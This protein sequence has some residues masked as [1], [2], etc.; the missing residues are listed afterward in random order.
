MATKKREKVGSMPCEGQNCESHTIGRP[1]I[2]YKS[3]SGTLGYKCDICGRG[4]YVKPEDDAH[5]EWLEAIKPD[6]APPQPSASVVTVA[7]SEILEDAT[8][9]TPAA[10]PPKPLSFVELMS[11]GRKQ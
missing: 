6:R 8:A 4:Y 2:V 10:I 5:R 11:G 7:P 1:V 9:S 3:A